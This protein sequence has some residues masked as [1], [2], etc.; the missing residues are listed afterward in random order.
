MNAL[1]ILRGGDIM[2]RN[3]VIAAAVA[4][5][6]VTLFLALTPSAEAVPTYSRR[7]GMECSVCHTMWGAL[8][9]AGV[10][11]RL[12]G[13][14]AINGKDLEPVS[15]DIEL[16][17]GVVIPSTLPFSIISGFGFD[18]RSEKLQ[19]SSGT[20][21]TQ[22]GSSL[23]LEDSSL[24][25]TGPIGQHLAAFIEFPMFET[26]EGE[27][28]PVGR[29]DADQA[30]QTGQIQFTTEKPVF[31]VAKFWWN[32]LLGDGAPRDSVNLLGGITHLPL[33]YASGKVRLSVNQ[34]PIYE[35]RALDLL[36]GSSRVDDHISDDN[37]LFRLSEPQVI[38]EVNG[39]VVPGGAV[40]DVPKKETF[41]FEYHLGIT[42]GSEEKSDNNNQKDLYGRFVMRWYRQS[43]GL[44]ALHS[45]DQYGDKI[46]TEG[47]SV[48]SSGDPAFMKPGQQSK[49]SASRI[50]LDATLSLAAIGVPVWLENQYMTNKESNPT[51]Y[52]K[53]FKWQGGFH[54]LNWQISKKA[55][56]YA[57]YDWIRGDSF[58]DTTAGGSTKAD[59]QETDEV[60]GFQYLIQQNV[61]FVAEYRHDVFEDKAP[62]PGKAQIT[63]DG[64]T[65]RVM[66][67]F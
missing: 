45:P 61:K 59:P 14:R 60:M 25:L 6:T 53:E 67:G 47:S 29:A 54:Q 3:A 48:S 13:Y 65:T 35:R 17:P 22:R 44:F 12:S 8:N 34:Y 19:P 11:F 37:G 23:G 1:T 21:Q 49:N 9:G 51:G 66:V 18:T 28:L 7:Y 30:G 32:N 63:S 27:F 4:L 43:L 46:R 10:T 15:K 33:G 64:L 55:I 36:I 50:G 24:F 16:S 39:M 52:G 56:T 40:T 20:G 5:L 41:W 57:R 38:F 58:D 42:N 2:K 62:N 31:E 26:K